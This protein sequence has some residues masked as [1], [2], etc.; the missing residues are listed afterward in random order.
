MSRNYNFNEGALVVTSISP[1]NPILQALAEGSQRRGARFI[2]VGDTK[3]PESFHLDGCDF[4]SVSR[5]R[6]LDFKFASICHERS[7][8]RKNIGYLIAIQCGANFIVETDDDNYPTEQFWNDRQETVS[9]DTVNAKGWVNAYSYF[10]DDFI[11]PRGFPLEL[12]R[13][14]NVS[15]APRSNSVP[16][17]SLIQQ[18]LADGNPDVDAVYRML[19]PLPF[20]FKKA[21]P[22]ILPR[23]AWCPFNS[24]NTT[25][26]SGAFP[27]LY[28]PTFCSFRMTDIWR[29][30]VAQR[31]L[32][33]ID[34]ELSF[35]Q[36]TVVQDR[37]E[38]SLLRDFED[39]IPGYL[40]NLK[41][42]DALEN[43]N[44]ESGLESISSNMMLCYEK[45]C[46]LDLIGAGELNLLETWLSD[47]LVIRHK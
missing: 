28:L 11:Y 32:W 38:H 13:G 46:S 4:F 39:E 23:H 36:A 26:F 8:T 43:I 45:L 1:P 40:N 21:A 16:R 17:T 41:I 34:S 3:S 2:V 47:L 15:F 44:L 7:Y 9:G 25:F 42:V 20:D 31:I 35:H 29:S 18:G 37:N 12:A 24:Q 19:F 33:T 10:A 27:L 22:L 30:F 6:D 14:T 5:Q